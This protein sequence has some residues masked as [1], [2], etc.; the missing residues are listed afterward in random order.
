MTI[1]RC[2]TPPTLETRLWCVGLIVAVT[3]LT[4]WPVVTHNF[5]EWD[6][7]Q[8][9][10]AVE[11]YWTRP[12]GN[13]YIP[14]TYGVWNLLRSLGRG[15]D[16]TLFHAFNLLIHLCTTLVV[17]KVLNLL[18]ER[19]GVATIAALV[20]AVHPVQ[21]EAVAWVSGMKDLLCGLFSMIAIWQYIVFTRRTPPLHYTVATIAFIAALL[22]KPTAVVV[23][24]IVGLVDVGLLSR[25]IHRTMLALTP[26]ILLSISGMVAAKLVQPATDVAVLS[27]LWAR[28]LIALDALGFYLRQ[29]ILPSK[30]C[31]DYGRNPM[32]IIASGALWI[33]WV[34]PVVLF[35]AIALS[36]KR[37]RMLVIAML[38]FVAGVAPVLGLVS[39]DFQL[40]STVAD[41][42]LYLPMVGVAMTIAWLFGRLN[43]RLTVRMG[44]LLIVALAARSFMQTWVWHD[45]VSLFNHNLAVN[46]SSW[47]SH[48]Q[49]TYHALHH[50]DP[51]GAEAHA[52]QAVHFIPNNGQARLNL[53]LAL[54]M[55]GKIDEAIVE[56][57]QAAQLM[58]NDP[59]P[60]THL[61]DARR[62][63]AATSQ[64]ATGSSTRTTRASPARYL[65]L[66]DSYTIGESVDASRRWPVQLAAMLRQRGMNIAD[67]QIIARTGWTTDELSRAIDAEKPQGPYQ[68]VSLLIGVNN[69]YRGRSA[70]EFREQFRALLKRS[71]AFAGDEPG[72]VIVLSIPD[73]GVT[74]FAQ[75]KD[76]GKI[77]REIDQFNR[78]SRE[79]CQ[80]LKVAFIDITPI[81]RRAP[82][83]PALI[84]GDG[85]HPSGQ[86]YRLWCEQASAAAQEALA[87]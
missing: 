65:A 67:P 24:I 66:G 87:R 36:R 9:T 23:P 39:F 4:Y 7:S 58:P 55:N 44:G 70:D 62:Y 30:L 22:S 17:W 33:T 59:E 40:Y 69:Q 18:F 25:T 1:D 43:P 74:P 13:L 85:L 32:S 3:L 60:R 37:P 29:I 53:G 77:A 63:Q 8:T 12:Q 71:I 83:E 48:V 56:F 54:A 5:V 68:L 34:V 46:P 31:L 78:I 35:A 19:P 41:H 72:R 73:W 45:T 80:V 6:D 11:D 84:A 27:P 42:Y 15:A 61:A 28:P 49:L 79:E 75:G 21:V 64:P 20:F 16:P 26:W 57:E 2:D 81:S 82:N 14:V 47:V 86:M 10:A 51:A 50:D 76:R 52:R 38:I